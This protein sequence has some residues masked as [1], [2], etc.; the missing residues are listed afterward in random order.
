VLVYGEFV[1][2]W[3]PGE[4]ESLAGSLDPDRR[5][6]PLNKINTPMDPN[7]KKRKGKNEVEQNKK[8]GRTEPLLLFL[9][10]RKKAPRSGRGPSPRESAFLGWGHRVRGFD[11]GPLAG[12]EKRGD[13]P[14]GGDR[15]TPGEQRSIISPGKG[16]FVIGKEGGSTSE[17]GKKIW[18]SKNREEHSVC[19]KKIPFQVQAPTKRSRR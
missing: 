17:K 1:V 13:L 2:R 14:R 5:S 3:E 19:G 9:E 6:G 10:G 18:E 16:F 7:K 15:P 11:P 8:G 4:K 12:V